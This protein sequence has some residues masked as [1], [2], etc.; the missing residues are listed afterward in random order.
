MVCNHG[1]AANVVTYNTLIH[2]FYYRGKFNEVHDLISDMLLVAKID[3]DEVSDTIMIDGL[4]RERKFD[5]ATHWFLGSLKIRLSRD[6]LTVLINMLVHSDRIIEICKAFSGMKENKKGFPL[7]Y[8]VFDYTIRSC[9]R[10]GFCHDRN[11]FKLNIILDTML[12]LEKEVS[13]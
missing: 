13:P 4:C 8:S 7:D 2:W 1:F 3:P 10:V 9:C 12:G 11:I 6:L 5:K